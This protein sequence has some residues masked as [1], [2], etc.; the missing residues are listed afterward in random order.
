MQTQRH[1]QG[2]TQ[3]GHQADKTG[4]HADKGN[5]GGGHKTADQKQSQAGAK[6]K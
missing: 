1:K 6:K 5:A 3:D 2:S 4:K